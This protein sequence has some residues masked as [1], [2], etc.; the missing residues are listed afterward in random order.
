MR[1]FKFFRGYEETNLRAV[2]TPEIAE[3]MI[4]QHN[5]NAADEL[6]TLLSEQISREIDNEII[7]T[8]TRRINGGD[9][10]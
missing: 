7:N 5:I 9:R 2:W 1:K 4:S 8:I 3:D 6:T 10:L